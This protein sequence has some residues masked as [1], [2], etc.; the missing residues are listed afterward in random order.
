MHGDEYMTPVGEYLD[1]FLSN[2]IPSKSIA[3]GMYSVTYENYV[4]EETEAVRCE[5]MEINAVNVSEW[6][7]I[8]KTYL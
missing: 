5:A 3:L 6:E 8:Y 4:H 1:V 7:N 2:E